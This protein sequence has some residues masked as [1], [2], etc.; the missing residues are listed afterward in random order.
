MYDRRT[1]AIDPAIFRVPAV[2]LEE[3]R[4]PGVVPEAI[5]TVATVVLRSGIVSPS[6]SVYGS[7]RLHV[8]QYSRNVHVQ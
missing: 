8:V 6:P 5:D 7:A 3:S 4:A 1:V 2:V